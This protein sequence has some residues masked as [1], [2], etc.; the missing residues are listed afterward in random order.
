MI[1]GVCNYRRIPFHQFIYEKGYPTRVI[2]PNLAAIDKI[3]GI[4]RHFSRKPVV[5]GTPIE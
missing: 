3:L 2:D 4:L 5:T 1:Y